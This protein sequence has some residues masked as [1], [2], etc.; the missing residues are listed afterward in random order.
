[1]NWALRGL[2]GIMDVL[3]F[4]F[5]VAL[6]ALQAMTPVGGG[7]AG[8]ATGAA[9]CWKLS[10]GVW[11]GI[12]NAASCALAGGVGG[13]AISALAT[14]IG[15]AIDM[16]ISSTFGVLLIALLWVSGRLYL[17][18]AIF[19]FVGEMTPGL[20]AFV[21]AW[22]LLVHRCIRQ[23]EEEQRHGKASGASRLLSGLAMAAGA[24]KLVPGIA[25]ALAAAGAARA[26]LP[27]PER[28]PAIDNQ[29]S[30]I[31]LQTRAFDGIRP[32]NDNTPT[33]AKAA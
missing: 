26:V 27:E 31:P 8:A 28:E 25:P 16:A 30:R 5:F 24:T 29:P 33:Y 9:V 2:A 13:A 21:P 17:I 7:L 11:E 19:G 18:P 14:P 22:S 6:L 23:Y 10:N 4:L 1:M 12:T 20:N 15:I 32:A 3:Q